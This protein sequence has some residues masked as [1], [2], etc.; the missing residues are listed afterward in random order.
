MESKRR[1]CI[2]SCIQTTAAFLSF[3]LSFFFSFFFFFSSPFFYYFSNNNKNNKNNKQIVETSDKREGGREG[4]AHWAQSTLYARS[5]SSR[6]MPCLF[7]KWQRQ[8]G[9][10]RSC[11]S[12]DVPTQLAV[13]RLC[14]SAEASSFGANTCERIWCDVRSFYY[15]CNARQ[16][17]CEK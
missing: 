6:L 5:M 7:G 16:H 2:V 11:P 13:Q 8:G 17:T 1:H 10:D 15:H 4:E 9:W 12:T 3:F 14:Y